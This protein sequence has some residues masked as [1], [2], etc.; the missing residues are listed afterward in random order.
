MANAR[1]WARVRHFPFF[2][3]TSSPD[4]DKILMIKKL[5]VKRKRRLCSPGEGKNG[6]NLHTYHSGF[7]V[8]KGEGEG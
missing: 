8:V 3:F 7:Q 1:T 5:E 2:T 6:R 4:E